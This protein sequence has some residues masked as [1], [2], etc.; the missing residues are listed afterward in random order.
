[1]DKINI[2]QWNCRSAISNKVNLE[3]LLLSEIWL[4]PERYIALSG[5][6]IVRKD[7]LDGKG[8]VAILLKQNI[9]YTQISGL[10]LDNIFYVGLKIRLKNNIELTLISVYIKPNTKIKLST[11]N[12]FFSLFKKP[13]LIGGDFNAHHEAWGCSESDVYGKTLSESLDLNNFVYLNNGKP[14]RLNPIN[15]RNSAIDLS[16]TSP[17]F[18][19]L[20]QWNTLNDTYGS[21]HFPIVIICNIS[22]KFVPTNT[23]KK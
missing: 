7:R 3:N 16:L 20:V 11:W 9:K 14:T 21:D 8:G 12:K 5:Y 4:K 2:G 13:F 23:R 18:Q 17:C 6:N 10:N 19:P 1:M 15:G 22:P